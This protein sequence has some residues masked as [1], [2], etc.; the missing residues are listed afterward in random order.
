MDCWLVVLMTFMFLTIKVSSAVEITD[1]SKTVVLN[2][3]VIINE[4]YHLHWTYDD[5]IIYIQ[6][7]FVVLNNV[8]EIT[9]MH[10]WFKYSLNLYD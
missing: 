10:H 6:V 5:K 4:N 8:F 9:Q 3:N 1:G 2:H 7:S